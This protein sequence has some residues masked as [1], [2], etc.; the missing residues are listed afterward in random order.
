MQLEYLFQIAW[1]LLL[2]AQLHENKK[3][4]IEF[5]IR[6]CYFPETPLLIKETQSH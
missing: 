2:V 1:V 6:V 4:L 5:V 3:Y